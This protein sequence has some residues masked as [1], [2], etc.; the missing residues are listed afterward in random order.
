MIRFLRR[1]FGPSIYDLARSDDPDPFVEALGSMKITLLGSLHREDGLPFEWVTEEELL[2]EI[3][4]AAIALAEREVFTPFS[5]ATDGVKLLP[6]F[7]SR[8]SVDSFC[9]A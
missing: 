6:F 5:Y 4:Q 9:G 8:R 1:F 7:T 2:A 3:N